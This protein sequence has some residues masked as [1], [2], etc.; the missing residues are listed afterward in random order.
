[1]PPQCVYKGWASWPYVSMTQVLPCQEFVSL[2][3]LCY[4][5]SGEETFSLGYEHGISEKSPNQ[6]KKSS[7]HGDTN[8]TC[9]LP[10]MMPVRTC[11]TEVQRKTV[12]AKVGAISSQLHIYVT[13]MTK[14]KVSFSLV[15]FFRLWGYSSFLRRETSLYKL[16]YPFT[17]WSWMRCTVVASVV[18]TRVVCTPQKGA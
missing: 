10:I 2:C 14:N 7:N 5:F 8:R 1:L 3:D 13:V 18:A 11:L 15:S 6:K 16:S 4:N 9:D 12:L 17:S